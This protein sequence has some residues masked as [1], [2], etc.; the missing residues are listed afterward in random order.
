[1][2]TAVDEGEAGEMLHNQ[3][4]KDQTTEDFQ[5]TSTK[6]RHKANSNER[7]SL[8]EKGPRLMM[9]R[10]AMPWLKLWRMN[11]V[12]PMTLTIMTQ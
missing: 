8:P 6:K 10:K 3:I 1:M 4:L 5:T 11:L 9:R 2:E 12:L 7:I